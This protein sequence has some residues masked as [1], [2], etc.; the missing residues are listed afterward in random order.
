[1][2]FFKLD[3][4]VL[5]LDCFMCDDFEVLLEIVKDLKNIEKFFMNWK[6]S[7]DKILKL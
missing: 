6:V 1:M 7:R 2:Y 5:F 4:F 3:F